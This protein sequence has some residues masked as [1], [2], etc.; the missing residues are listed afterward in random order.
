MCGADL[1]AAASAA[2]DWEQSPR[3]RGRF[4]GDGLYRIV[5]GAIPACAG[6]ILSDLR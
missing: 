6:P 1:S 3:V 5:R 2:S 4:Y